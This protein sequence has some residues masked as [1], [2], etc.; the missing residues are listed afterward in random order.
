MGKGVKN[1]KINNINSDSEMAQTKWT[2]TLEKRRR[3][4]KLK[5]R[6]KDSASLKTKAKRA[7][8]A[9]KATK[10]AMPRNRKTTS[11]GKAPQKQLAT[12]AA[13]KQE[14]EREQNPKSLVEIML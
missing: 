11:D 1:I 5:N 13:H 12:K 4:L 7:S 9:M 2:E 10:A 3:K 8:K 14:V 6:N